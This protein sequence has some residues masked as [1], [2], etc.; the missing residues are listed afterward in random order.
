M[1]GES[2]QSV[3][4]SSRVS[5][6]CAKADIAVGTDRPQDS[7]DTELAIELG[8]FG[9]EFPVVENQ[10]AQQQRQESERQAL[11]ECDLLDGDS[12]GLRVDSGEAGR[13]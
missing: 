12:R 2:T 9:G 1:A 13:L 7:R 6:S 3:C 5:F 8:A 10:F 11:Q 4:S